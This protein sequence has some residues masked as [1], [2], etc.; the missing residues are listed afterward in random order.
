MKPL[1]I[2]LYFF[3]IFIFLEAKDKSLLSRYTK[4]YLNIDLNT[5]LRMRSIIGF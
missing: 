3:M 2:S 4:S 1:F 5:V